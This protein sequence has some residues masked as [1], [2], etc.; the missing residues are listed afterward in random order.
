M[1]KSANITKTAPLCQGGQHYYNFIYDLLKTIDLYIDKDQDIYDHIME[2]RN[3]FE[4][5][6]V[7]TFDSIKMIVKDK[8]NIK[9]YEFVKELY[10]KY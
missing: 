1:C 9:Q 2:V 3:L 4:K 5:S 7:V 10:K 8:K 6:P